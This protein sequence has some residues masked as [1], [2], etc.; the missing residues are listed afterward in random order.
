[1]IIVFIYCVYKM[2]YQTMS[3]SDSDNTINSQ[4]TYTIKVQYKKTHMK[5][6]NF[7]YDKKPRHNRIIEKYELKC[8]KLNRQ[9]ESEIEKEM[10]QINTDCHNLR[11]T[12]IEEI[13]KKSMR[14]KTQWF[15]KMIC[16]MCFNY[17][18]EIIRTETQYLK[19]VAKQ[20][21]YR[22]AY[23]RQKYDILINQEKKKRDARLTK[24]IYYR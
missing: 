16:G 12:K 17:H 8:D 21:K 20:K 15:Q 4:Q 13:N 18:K 1:M 7:N 14:I 10:I 6:H 23:I 2:N 24:Y 9:M 22:L 11:E 5:D 3:S 19:N